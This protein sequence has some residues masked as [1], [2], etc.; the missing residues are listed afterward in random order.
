LDRNYSQ[1]I[2]IV[3]P[4]GINS[5][6]IPRLAGLQGRLIRDFF[7]NDEINLD[8]TF[9]REYESIQQ[10]YRQSLA[11]ADRDTEEKI[12]YGIKNKLFVFN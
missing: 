6:S 10:I 4:Y 12:R 9:Q 5:S 11:D 8:E 1:I 3:L 2:K 7:W